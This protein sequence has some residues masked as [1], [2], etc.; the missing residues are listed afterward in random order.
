MAAFPGRG[1]RLLAASGGTGVPERGYVVLGGDLPRRLRLRLAGWAGSAPAASGPGRGATLLRHETQE[2]GVR[3]PRG[4]QRP[5]VQP[6]GLGAG[7]DQGYDA[8]GDPGV[9]LF[10]QLEADLPGPCDPAFPV[11]PP[12]GLSRALP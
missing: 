10:R 1:Y 9:M 2:L 6:F 4:L 3:K 8:V 7:L 12:G 5:L 11:G